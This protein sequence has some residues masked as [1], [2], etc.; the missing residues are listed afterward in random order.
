MIL[1]TEFDLLWIPRIRLRYAEE[2]DAEL[3]ISNAYG[4]KLSNSKVT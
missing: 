1:L 2:N 4:A 3:E